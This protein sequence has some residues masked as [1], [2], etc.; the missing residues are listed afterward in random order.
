MNATGLEQVKAIGNKVVSDSTTEERLKVEKRLHALETRFYGLD[1]IGKARM[2]ELQVTFL[3]P[4]TIPRNLYAAHLLYVYSHIEK[5]LLGFCAGSSGSHIIIHCVTN[6]ACTLSLSLIS[7]DA[8]TK[9]GIYESHCSTVSNWIKTMEEKSASLPVTPIR[10][11]PLSTLCQDIKVLIIIIH[12]EY[13]YWL[14]PLL[15]VQY[16]KFRF[17]FP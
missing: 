4:C 3:V 12:V 9:A 13:M 8:H 15:H 7:Q 10:S 1:K 16:I 17:T 6:T 2:S 5:E 14:P 11:Q